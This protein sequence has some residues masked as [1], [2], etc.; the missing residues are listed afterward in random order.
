MMTMF[1]SDTQATDYATARQ[2]DTDRYARYFHNMLDR[3]S[4]FAPSQFECGFVSTAHTD[5]DIDAT[6]EAARAAMG[7]LDG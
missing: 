2:A 3:G 4:Y 7:A 6:V 1:F 5:D